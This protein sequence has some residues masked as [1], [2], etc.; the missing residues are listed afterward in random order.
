MIIQREHAMTTNNLNTEKGVP[1]PMSSAEPLDARG[2]NQR[3]IGRLQSGDV[4][5]ALADFH[6]AAG[7]QPDYPE[8]WNNAG[9]VRQML[10][11][12]AEAVADFDR[13]LAVRP[14]YPEALTNRGR[15]RQAL[16]DVVGARADFDQ[17]LRTATASPFAAS[18]LHNRG[19]LRQTQGDLAGALADFD[20]AL[21][22]DSN[23]TS[24]Y[25]ARG[26]ARKES[27]DM[28]GAL[29]DFNKALEQNPSQ[30]LATVYHGR[31]GVRVLQNDF[32]GAVADYDRALSLE[33]ER[34]L[35]YISRGNARYHQRDPRGM[36]DYRMAFRLD[37]AGAAREFVRIVATDAQRDAEGVLENCRKHLR[38]NDR[39]VLAYVRRGLTLLVL[40]REAEAAPDLAQG[41]ALLADMLPYFQRILDR[42]LNS[43]SSPA[44]AASAGPRAALTMGV[45]D[46]VFSQV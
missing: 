25:V 41:R 29:A 38:L 40:G 2:L 31:G 44:L 18:V 7:R 9:L 3:G 14:D 36:L 23:H 6:A 24:T 22:I 10:G 13:A 4:A 8:P 27:D 21:V 45:I 1:L 17:A 16:G 42:M 12:L 11:Q 30:G 34:N 5:G 20:Q 33:P 32:A 46:G 15:A 37:A 26:L 28:K 43:R 19:L 39:D 35:F